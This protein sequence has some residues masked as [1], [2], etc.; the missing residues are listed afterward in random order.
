MVLII[1][2]GYGYS[3]TQRHNAISQARTPTMDKLWATCPHELISGSG[4]GVGL[5][6][7]QMGNSEVG[8]L[9]LGAGRIVYQEFSRITKAIADGQFFDNEVLLKAIDKAVAK[10]KAVHIMGLLSPGGVHSHREHLFAAIE[11]AA[12]RGAKQVYLHAILDGRDT[13]PQSAAESIKLAEE[14]FSALGIGQIASLA[15]RYY[16]MDRDKRWERVQLAYDMLTAGQADYQAETALIGLEQAYERGETDEFVKPTLIHAA[17]DKPVVIGDGDAVLFMNFRAD[18]AR[19][20]TQCF[21]DDEFTGFERQVRPKLSAHVCL[22]QYDANFKTPVAFPPTRLSNIFGEYLAKKGLK[23]LRIAET[24]KYA[25]VTFFFNGGVEE[26]FS[27][28]DRELI[29]SPKVATYDLQPE[30]NAELVTDKLVAAIH[31]QKYDAIICNYANADMVGHTGNYQAAIQ[32][33]ECLDH[34][35]AQVVA[36]LDEVGGEV[37][38]TAD[39]GNADEMFN[40]ATGQPHTAHTTNPVPFIY[41]GRA[42]KI[43]KQHGILADICP[44]MLYLMG[45]P[46]PDEM[47]GTPLVELLD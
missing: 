7:A 38:I 27:G 42:A 45:L 34:C 23:Q 21:I 22:T 24:E 33:I 8:H 43:A 14:K 26:P 31:G 12:Q 2:D 36:A 11:L 44:T 1:L 4:E 16:T 41:K 39:H 29:P 3:E 19:E 10:Q 37:I 5:P 18:R 46:I 6:P 15:G 20:I 35:L 25:H 28:E 32:A 30:M 47:T 13:P 40:E 9:N 17:G